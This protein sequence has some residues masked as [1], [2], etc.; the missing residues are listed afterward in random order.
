MLI[1]LVHMLSEAAKKI[2][3][4]A[5]G[6]GMWLY[7]PNYQKW[8]SPED[9]KHIF[10]FADAPDEFLKSLQIKHPAEAIH[11]GF[12]RLF[13]IQNKLAAF[14]KRVTDYYKK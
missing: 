10:S 4:E 5:K 9:F 6:K 14:T 11:V 13:E 8:Y 2:A 12:Q 3:D 7:D 1:I